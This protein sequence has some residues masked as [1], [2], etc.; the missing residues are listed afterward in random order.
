MLAPQQS[1]LLTWLDAFLDW[2]RTPAQHDPG[3]VDFRLQV[4]ST[5]ARDLGAGGLAPQPAVF[6]APTS[7]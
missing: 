5:R 7:L 6:T 1:A 2:T 4:L 3:S